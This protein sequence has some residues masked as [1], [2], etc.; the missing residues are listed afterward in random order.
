MGQPFSSDRPDN[1]CAEL[2]QTIY[3]PNYLL[4]QYDRH[5]RTYSANTTEHIRVMLHVR[6]IC[7]YRFGQFGQNCLVWFSADPEK[8]EPEVLRPMSSRMADTEMRHHLA[9][10]TIC[11]RK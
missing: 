4:G 11:Q 2:N 1:V 7:H 9:T 8:E 10:G 6:P 5:D 3:L